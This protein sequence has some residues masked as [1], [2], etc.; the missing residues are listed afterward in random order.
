M[1][2]S[3]QLSVTAAGN[4]RNKSDVTVLL[5]R[6]DNTYNAGD[7]VTGRIDVYLTQDIRAAGKPFILSC[8]VSFTIKN[9]M[10]ADYWHARV[11]REQTW[12]P[13]SKKVIT[14]P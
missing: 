4:K 13:V 12:K 14:G 9:C 2:T 5:S 1:L 6:P 10:F 8:C 3:Q 7:T 11:L